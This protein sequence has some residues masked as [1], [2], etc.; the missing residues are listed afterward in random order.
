MATDFVVWN[1]TT[2]QLTLIEVKDFR[3]ETTL[4]SELHHIMARKVRDSLATLAIACGDVRSDLH[5][6][7][8]NLAAATKITAVLDIQLPHGMPRTVLADLQ[9]K[10]DSMM[11]NAVRTRIAGGSAPIPWT[12]RD[13]T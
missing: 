3:T 9:Q 4:P 1:P 13:Q 5:H 10:L 8:R 7:S 2:A 11:T 6:F 12:K